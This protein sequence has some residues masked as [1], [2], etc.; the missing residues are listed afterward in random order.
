M[1]LSVND[2]EADANAPLPFAAIDVGRQPFEVCCCCKRVGS[3]YVLWETAPIPG[4]RRRLLCIVGP[5]W[6]MVGRSMK[7]YS[8]LTFLIFLSHG[9]CCV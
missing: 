5:Y 4:E 9:R 1:L 8:V 7:Y 6:Q 3:M 2:L